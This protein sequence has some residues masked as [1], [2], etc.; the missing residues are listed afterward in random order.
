MTRN[1]QQHQHARC[2]CDGNHRRVERASH[3][4]RIRGRRYLRQA[5]GRRQILRRVRGSCQSAR[6]CAIVNSA[7]YAGGR[8]AFYRAL[9]SDSY[10]AEHEVTRLTSVPLS[11]SVRR[12]RLGRRMGRT[13]IDDAPSRARDTFPIVSSA[14][15]LSLSGSMTRGMSLTVRAAGQEG[16]PSRHCSAPRLEERA[17]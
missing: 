4:A 8:A 1:A 11:W 2:T 14:R 12:R 5:I 17:P 9:I 10:R 7:R 3:G 15:Y 6:P 16:G 13:Q